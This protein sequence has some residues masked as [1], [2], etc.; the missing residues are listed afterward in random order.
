MSLRVV[1]QI[2]LLAIATLVIFV[3]ADGFIDSDLSAAVNRSFTYVFIIE[4]TMKI[5]AWGPVNILKDNLNKV[6]LFIIIIAVMEQIL[7]GLMSSFRYSRFFTVA[8]VFRVFRILTKMK[9]MKFIVNVLSITISSFVYLALLLIL[10]LFIYSL[11]GMQL[12][13]RGFD[14]LDDNYEKY[15]FDTFSV[16]YTTNFDIVTMDDIT[17]ILSE[18]FKSRAGPLVTSVYVCFLIFFGNFILL[19]LFLAI[20]LDAFTENLDPNSTVNLLEVFFI[21]FV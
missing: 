8:K 6:D 4:I 13:G 17:I 3:A 2:I 16:A 19:N 10:L 14:K 7:S 15:N 5:I 20:L 9:F 1:D 18:G 21:K 11:L 12:F